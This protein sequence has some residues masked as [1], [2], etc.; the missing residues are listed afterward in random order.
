M[1]A[2]ATLR[3]RAEAEA[4]SLPPLFIRAHQLAGTVLLGEHGRRRAGIGDDFWQY[5]PVAP[6]DERRN[7][8]WRRSARS[9]MQ[10]VRQLELK[11]ARNI[12]IW[13][14]GGNSMRF[15]SHK[16]F[17]EKIDRARLL[18]LAV[19]IL[20]NRAG[21]S[22]GLMG[23]SLPPKCGETQ[24][25]RISTALEQMD[26]TE[27][28]KPPVEQMPSNGGALF[29]SDFLGSTESVRDALATAAARGVRGVI[30][31]LLDPVE[32][33][34]PYRGRTL[35]E[36]VGGSYAHETANAS[37]LQNRYLERLAERKA[38]LESLC[39]AARWQYGCFHTTQ[40]ARAMLLWLYRAI[41]GVPVE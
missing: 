32:E 33:S 12:L 11:I 36:S 27:Y 18:S 37:D 34:F 1:S 7:I 4:S 10:Y 17:P 40:T 39:A 22:V 5:R 29:I 25:A 15:S 2:G 9:D 23:M 24:L 3:G 35:F 14:D 16:T 19:S 8:D 20:L 30:L 28:G 31:Q 13:M 6:G 26:E 21:E 41:E 38:E